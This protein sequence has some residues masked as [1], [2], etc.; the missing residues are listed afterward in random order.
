MKYHVLSI[1][2]LFSLKLSTR[3]SLS[4]ESSEREEG[5]ARI[6]YGEIPKIYEQPYLVDLVVVFNNGKIKNCAGALVSE[7]Y[8]L[9]AAHCIKNSK[10]IW[11]V[12]VIYGTLNLKDTDKPYQ[13]TNQTIVHPLYEVS[14]DGFARNDIALV[15]LL[16]P[17]RLSR[18]V[19]LIKLPDKSQVKK[20]FKGAKAVVAGWGLTENATNS[21]VLKKAIVTVPEDDLLCRGP[22]YLICAFGKK[23]QTPC[24]GD[25]GSPLVWRKKFI[26]GI[27]SSG[28]CLSESYYTRV[29][30]YL[31]WIAKNSD[32]RIK[33]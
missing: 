5:Q 3:A 14:N 25:S 12:N 30:M 29:T 9:T 8:V 26:I 31:D 16:K 10:D 24:S 18:Q 20:R 2:I 27:L 1:L 21:F 13:T 7:K 33:Q 17:V 22:K 4:I 15:K 28:N 19:G 11:S 32:V 6:L 23:D